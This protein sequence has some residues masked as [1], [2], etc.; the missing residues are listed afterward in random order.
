MHNN[1]PWVALF[2][3]TGS[4]IAK[5]AKHL[6]RW[7]DYIITNADS[8]NINDDVIFNITHMIDNHDA[9]TLDILHEL[10]DQDTLITLHGWLRIVPKPICNKYAIFNGHPGLITRYGELKGKDPQDKILKKL[11]HYKYYGSVVHKVTP[12]IDGGEVV[13]YCERRNDLTFTNFDDNIRH[14]SLTSWLNFFNKQTN[15]IC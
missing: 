11:D 14:A 7:P 6:R 4:E 15:N 1:T 9:Q 13:A 10:C 2:S 5:L 3:Q 12:E 8:D